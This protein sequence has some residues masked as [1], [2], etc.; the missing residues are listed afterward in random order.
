METLSQ[1]SVAETYRF[2]KEFDFAP[3]LGRDPYA[4]LTFS[5]DS[6]IRLDSRDYHVRLK[7]QAPYGYYSTDNDIYFETWITNPKALRRLLMLQVFD[8]RTDETTSIQVRLTDGTDH[9]YWDGG[10]WSVAGASDWNSEGDIN[11]HIQD[12]T[13]LPNRQ[14]GVVVNLRTTDQYYTPSVSEIRVLME[15]RI[16]YLEDIIFRSLIPLIKENIRPVANFPLTALEADSSTIDLNDYEMDTNFNVVDV[17]AVF[18]HS[19]DPE[20]LTDI[21]DNYNPTTKVI[22]LTTPILTGEIPFLLFRYEPMVAYTTHQ[23]YFEVPKVPCITLQ[24]LEVPTESAYNL[25]AREGVVDKGTGN[26][27]LVHEP[28]KATLDFRIH[29]TTDHSTDEM[30]LMSAVMKFF[31]ENLMIT[32]IG[33][34]EKYRLRI[35]REFRDLITPD[36]ADQRTF[37]TRFEIVDVR[38]PFVSEDT[39]GVMRR[40][41]TFSEPEPPHEDPILGGRFVVFTSH[42]DDGPSA[43]EESFEITE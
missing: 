2:I 17:E 5:D 41:L 15:I 11:A 28:W 9:Y 34:D 39:T 32:S 13:I 19:T 26:A 43:W 37:W 3:G 20:F 10:A 22:T 12:F 4:E 42:T 31:D 25:G 27:V 38:M 7:K 8:H 18:N 36:R 1:T 14:F 21:L 23:D 24:R 33:L 29:V 35:I 6:L 16:D 40:V 30:R